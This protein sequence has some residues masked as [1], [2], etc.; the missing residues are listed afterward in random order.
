[1]TDRPPVVLVFRG[2]L[3]PGR[4]RVALAS[5]SPRSAARPPDPAPA[6]PVAQATA[7]LSAVALVSQ[8]TPSASVHSAA[9]ARSRERLIDKRCPRSSL[10]RQQRRSGTRRSPRRDG[11]T[12]GRVPARST[13][14][15]SHL[16]RPCRRS[17]RRAA[18]SFWLDGGA[19]SRRLRSSRPF[20]CVGPRRRERSSGDGLPA[21][22]RRHPKQ[23]AARGAPIPED[24]ALA[25]PFGHG[26]RAAAAG[27]RPLVPDVGRRGLPEQV[28]G[29]VLRPSPPVRRLDQRLAV[30]GRVSGLPR[31]RRRVD[32]SVFFVRGAHPSRRQAAP[33]GPWLI[34]AI[35]RGVRDEPAWLR[36]VAGAILARY[37]RVGRF[38]TSTFAGT[39][40]G[41]FEDGPPLG[42]PILPSSRCGRPTRTTYAGQW[43]DVFHRV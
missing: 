28:R 40:P 8:A 31:A 20:C 36:M 39:H 10:R 22:D 19:R 1:V 24:L 11:S 6:R 13:R 38:S 27:G 35:V 15:A 4:T 14:H 33:A 34:G 43:I 9:V 7:A 32:P 12:T 23:A 17:R 21:D 37:T 26:G 29:P 25:R 5:S 16:V 30:L 3:R 18:R 41:Y 2:A 42:P